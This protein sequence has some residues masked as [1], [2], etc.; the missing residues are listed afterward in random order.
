MMESTED[1]RQRLI[2]AMGKAFASF[3]LSQNTKEAQVMVTGRPTSSINMIYNGAPLEHVKQVTYLGASFNEKGKTTKEVKRRVT[4]AKKPGV[5]CEIYGETNNSNS[6]ARENR[7]D[8][9]ATV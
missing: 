4:I 1:N 3:G 8:T 5:T 7:Y 6:D 2:N 9:R